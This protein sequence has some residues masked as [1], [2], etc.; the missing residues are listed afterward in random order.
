MSRAD[1]TSVPSPFEQRTPGH[2]AATFGAAL[3]LATYSD[4]FVFGPRVAASG[5]LARRELVEVDV[6]GWS[7][8]WTI[9][10]ACHTTRVQAK[11]ARALKTVLSRWLEEAFVGS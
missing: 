10:L 8:S 9:Y 2:S 11:T 5:Q 3:E 1:A 4:H 7:V 6:E